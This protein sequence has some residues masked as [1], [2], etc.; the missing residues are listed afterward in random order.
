MK[1]SFA[2]LIVLFCVFI[3]QSAQAVTVYYQPTPFPLK[4]AN[5]TTM[6]QD[7]ISIVHVW[8]GWLPSVYYGQTFQRD[9]SLQVGGWGD[10][11]RTYLK[12]DIIGLPKNVDQAL[13]WLMP[14]SRG[15][16]STPIPYAVCQVISPWNLSMTWNTQ[17]GIGTC[18]GW[19]SAP[20]AGNWSGFWLSGVG[21]LDWYNQWQSQMLVNNG[22]M[23][24]P[25][26]V[27]NNFD[28]FYNTLYSSYS[29]DP[30][31]DARRPILQLTFTPPTG[32][33]N[34]K[35]PLPGGYKWL[36]TNEIGGYECKG[37]TPWPDTT[38]QGNNYF[39]LDFFPTNVKDGGGSYTGNIPILA[40]A[41]GTVIDVAQSNSD[42][43]GWYITLDHGNGYQTRYLHFKN[44]AA[45]ANG[46]WLNNGNWVNQGDQLGFMGGTGGYPVHLH[47]NFWLNGIG[48]ST[49]TNLTYAVM[50][51]WLLKSFQTECAVDAN[52]V[53]TNRIRYYHSSNTPTG[54]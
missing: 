28:V 11:Y 44:H 5:G 49:T 29:V 16:S 26:A 33:P 18:Y 35:M 15:D 30:Y 32:M 42:S 45:R 46:T 6:P 1:K 12:F 34:F 2:V 39:S 20:T 38:H 31:A 14:Y 53:P 9:S 37:E 48:A 23:L 27:N 17:P 4:K 3:T 24:F 51:G 52:G 13:I 50:D 10:Q 40:V 47:I 41:G 36:L 19:Y 8:N 22:V 21:G 25:Q 43:R 7:N 54:N